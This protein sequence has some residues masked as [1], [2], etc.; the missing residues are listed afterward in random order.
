MIISSTS[1]HANA[2]LMAAKLYPNVSFVQ[3]G[4]T[5]TLPN[6]SVLSYNG[7]DMY[8]VAGIFC[9]AMTS[10][11]KVGFIHP[12]APEASISTLNAFY[13]GV[14]TANP[15]AEVYVVFTGS[16]LNPDRTV[17]ACNILLNQTGVD[18][19]AGQQ[20]DF[21]L[22]IEAMNAGLLAVGVNGYPLR[23]LYGEAVGMSVLRRWDGPLKTY[24][25]LTLE[26]LGGAIRQ[27]ITASFASGYT[28]LDTPSHL[29]P[30]RV[31]DQ[32][33]VATDLLNTTNT[34]NKSYYCSPYVAEMGLDPTTNCLNNTSK[35]TNN[36]LSGIHNL[37]SYY[38]PLED[39]PFPNGTRIAV[40]IL[41]ALLF[42]CTAVFA[43]LIFRL[44]KDAVIL[45]SSPLFLGLITVGVAMVFCATIAWVEVK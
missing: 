1:D 19:I 39:V 7:P 3:N 20:D 14:K 31:W 33:E 4:G 40:I 24:A 30:D 32:V 21:T 5:S 22:Q 45:A 11:N 18:M 8:Y 35:F 17:G 15:N 9:G 26:N 29:V 27:D 36:M 6:L 38:V 23:N 28:Y 37:G 44:R 12:S 10:V 34:N 25:Q 41:A 43:F 16:Y 13:V 2:A 42:L